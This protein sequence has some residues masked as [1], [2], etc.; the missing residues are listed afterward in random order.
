MAGELTVKAMVR[1][2]GGP[3]VLAETLGVTRQAI[4]NWIDENRVPA[5]RESQVLQL[6]VANGINWRPPG[7]SPH[8]QLRF[9]PSP[10]GDAGAPAA[11]AA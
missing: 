11:R 6:C 5:A 8:I 9:N 7:W 1:D 10:A 2:L 4:Q 3:P